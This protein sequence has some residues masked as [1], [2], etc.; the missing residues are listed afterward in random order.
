MGFIKD[1][2]S[3]NGVASSK[4]VLGGI[5]LLVVVG[6]WAVDTYHNGMGTHETDLAEV[7][8]GTAC[9]LLGITSF[10]SAI[11]RIGGGEKNNDNGKA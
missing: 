7:I 10:A 6:V 2:L 5:C 3:E 4:R 1:M 9:I 8:V 11:S